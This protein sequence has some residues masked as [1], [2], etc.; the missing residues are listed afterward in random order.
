MT[1]PIWFLTLSI[2]RACYMPEF[3]NI[4]AHFQIE[5]TLQ[6]WNAINGGLINRTFWIRTDKRA[7]VLQAINSQV[8]KNPANIMENIQRV[9][10]Y[11]ES[12]D[13]PRMVLRPIKTKDE[14]NFYQS[15]SN[16]YWRLFPFFENTF[17]INRVD[18][19]EQAYR[20]AYGFGEYVRY[21]TDLPPNELHV[22]IPDFHNTPFRFQ[23]FQQSIKKATLRRKK[24]AQ[25]LIKD[26]LGL[27][28]ILKKYTSFS[29]ALRVVHYDTK[30]NN[31][32]FDSNTSK[33]KVII[34]LD[35]LMPGLLPYDFGDM[36]RTYTSSVDEN[37]TEMS[38]V[39]VRKV[40]LE[41]VTTGYLEGI[42]N[43]I[44][45]IEKAN[46]YNGAALVIYEQ[47]LRFLSDYL[48]GNVYYLVK[49]ESQNLIR[50]KNQLVL[51]RAFLCI[52]ER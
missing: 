49:Y 29:H 19:A 5:G 50:A 42:R 46:L 11:L 17:S 4:L 38:E 22:T 33:V 10:D 3:S 31:V 14:Q 12:S 32:L 27:Q 37:G 24:L 39:Y 8:F 9:A 23:A 43:A 40:V 30:I 28:F 7:Y 15:Q 26:L 6:E 20:A 45:P 52:K 18:S 36:V 44:R 51:L 47:A 48:L 34:D 2:V 41:A 16:E 1:G 25:T 21:L 35:T 13:Y